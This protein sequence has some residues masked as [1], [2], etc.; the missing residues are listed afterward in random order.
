ML[1]AGRI[2]HSDWDSYDTRHTD[3]RPT[4]MPQ[5][6]IEND[7]W[8]A[9]RQFYRW[10]SIMRGVATKPDLIGAAWHVAYAGVGKNSSLPGT[11]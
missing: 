6:A 2:L 4:R 10:H 1:K 3:F 7:Y 9:Y 11:W 8:W 5:V